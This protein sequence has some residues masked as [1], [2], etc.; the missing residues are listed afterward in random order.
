MAVSPE[1]TG[2]V[3]QQDLAH[4]LDWL[5]GLALILETLHEDQRGKHQADPL[6][7]A[8]QS[9]SGDDGARVDAHMVWEPLRYQREVGQGWAYC[10]DAVDELR[11]RLRR[12]PRTSV[13]ARPV[14]TN[15]ED[16]YP[17]RVPCTPSERSQIGKLG[18]HTRWA[19]EADRSAATQAARDGFMRRFED[20]VDPERVLPVEERAVRAE[21]ARRAYFQ[22]LALKSAQARRKKEQS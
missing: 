20:Q 6:L 22:R 9:M 14:V 1:H 2:P 7:E 10:R 11:G 19:N 5:D 12:L 3:R 15:P 13:M 21:S 16:G 8:L 18:A 17:T 4:T